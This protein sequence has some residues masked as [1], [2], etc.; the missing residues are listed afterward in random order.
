MSAGE[1]NSPKD[2]SKRPDGQPKRSISRAGVLVFLLEIGFVVFLAIL[3]FR[4]ESLQRSIN[5]WILFFYSFPSQFLVAVTPHEPVYLYFSK[6]HM[7]LAVTLVSV[8]GTALT[9]VLN[10]SVLKFIF[11]LDTLKKVTHGSAIQK[12]VRL[13]EKAPFI[14]LLV[15][16]LTPIPFAPFRFLV[17]LARYPLL[18]YVLAVLISRGLRFYL[19]AVFGKTV[20][21]PN[22]LIV[23]LFLS[24]TVLASIPIVKMLSRR[25]CSSPGSEETP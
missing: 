21:V 24:F 22:S 18:R 11:D 20:K 4:S 12:I 9:E 5:L 6:F 2:V 7:P 25:K 10:Y 14:A 15:A 8:T 23:I 17:V 16:G 19:L 3:W 1:T 13:Y